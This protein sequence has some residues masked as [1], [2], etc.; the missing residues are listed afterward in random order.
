MS[1]GAAIMTILRYLMWG[2]LIS[3]IVHLFMY[4]FADFKAAYDWL[5]AG[6]ILLFITLMLV[7]YSLAMYQDGQY[8]WRG[9][10]VTRQQHPKMFWF[11]VILLSSLSVGFLFATAIYGFMFLKS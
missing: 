1:K 9:L 4:D 6:Q 2:L 8:E 10:I 7:I 3:I 5:V 11:N